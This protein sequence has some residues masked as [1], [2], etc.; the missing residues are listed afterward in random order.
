MAMLLSITFLK[1]YKYSEIFESSPYY[2]TTS[3]SSIFY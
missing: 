2:L 3:F 1:M